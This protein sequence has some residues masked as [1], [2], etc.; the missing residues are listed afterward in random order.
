MSVDSP[1]DLP[2]QKSTRRS[3]AIECSLAGISTSIPVIRID[4]F[5]EGPA[6]LITAG[7]HG[8]EYP[9]I[10]ALVR[11]GQTIS[12]ETF[13]GTLVLVP[14]ANGSAFRERCAFITPPDG[15]NLNRTFPGDPNGSYT[16]QLAH[17]LIERLMSP[18]DAYVDL[19]SGDLVESL[20]PFTSY[21]LTDNEIVDKRSEE[22]ARAFGF[23]T[24]IRFSAKDRE[25]MSHV[26]AATRGTPSLLAEIGGQGVWHDGE[27][28]SFLAGIASLMNCLEMTTPPI[29]SEVQPIFYDRFDWHHSKVEGLWYPAV[30]TGERVKAGETLGE[31]KTIFGERLQEIVADDDGLNVFMLS[32][33]ST[34]PGDPLIGLAAE[35]EVS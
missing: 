24:V 31:V 12:P 17:V 2:F 19:H 28:L 20:H 18:A 21:V 11:L 33:L 14:I 22:M 35:R 5:A 25:S 30:H 27:V 23:E 26:A 29:G 9:G 10:E 7:I 6:L 32:A 16:Q 13:R 15:K 34:R 8:A 3:H 4:G 1:F